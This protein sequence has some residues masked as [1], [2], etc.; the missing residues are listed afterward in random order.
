MLSHNR[1]LFHLAAVLLSY[2]AL[3]SCA[4]VSYLNGRAPDDLIF[5]KTTTGA[6]IRL[7]GQELTAPEFSLYA[8]GSVIK[9]TY[10]DGQRQLARY[11]LSR[12][13]FMDIYQT[14]HSRW[15]CISD[16][17]ETLNTLKNEDA[18]TA[19]IYVQYIFVGDTVTVRPF[20]TVK[21]NT[22]EKHDLLTLAQWMDTLPLGKPSPFI[23]DSVLLFVKK[24]EKADPAIY[25]LWPWTAIDLS[26]IYKKPVS[27]YEPNVPEN[28]T[29][30][31]G[32]MA[33]R[34]QKTIPAHGQYAKYQ[35]QNAVYAVGY[36]P[37]LPKE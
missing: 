13:A 11:R 28:S 12:K 9:Y 5:R 16:T 22:I 29:H 23:G 26:L 17:A 3:F 6:V 30:I 2:T 7:A 20:R 35:Y 4:T 24:I 18:L 1:I 27:M 8:D 21:K 25:P 10:R 33:R 32:S 15:T 19:D 36:R 14:I 31:T 37:L 34:I